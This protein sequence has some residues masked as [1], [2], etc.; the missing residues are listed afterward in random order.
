MKSL[1]FRMAGRLSKEPKTPARLKVFTPSTLA[2]KVLFISF[3]FFSAVSRLYAEE[4]QDTPFKVLASNFE[5]K[6]EPI[7]EALKPGPEEAAKKKKKKKTEIDKIAERRN[8]FFREEQEK[9]TRFINDLRQSR[10]SD[11]QR[12]KKAAEF[13]AKEVERKR[14]FAEKMNREILKN[15]QK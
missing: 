9:R 12:Q 7:L 4:A 13:Y 10:L 15:S 3:I 14:R 2:F 5:E 6:A 11:G 8:K 1:F